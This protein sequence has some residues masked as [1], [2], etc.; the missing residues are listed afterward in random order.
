MK[1]TLVPILESEG[2]Q[3]TFPEFQRVD[4]GSLQLL[5]IQFDKNGGGFFM[6]FCN[7]P[8]GD[9]ETS[10]GEI[11]PE[12]N[13]TVAHTPVESRARL[14]QTGNRNSLAEDWFRYENLST[15]EVERLAKHVAELLPQISDWLREKKIGENIST[16]DA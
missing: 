8:P 13:I 12:R 14:Q 16:T 9:L 5:S 3:G 6:E 10:W 4:C 1:R 11:V 7:H 2:F 15:D